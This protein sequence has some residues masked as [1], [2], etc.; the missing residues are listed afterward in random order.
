M[1]IIWE[2]LWLLCA[3]MELTGND[4]VEEEYFTLF[5]AGGR[6]KEHPGV[7]L[8]GK[9]IN[10]CNHMGKGCKLIAV[11]HLASGLKN[12]KLY[13]REHWKTYTYGEQHSVLVRKG[14]GINY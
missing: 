5:S 2:V 4:V 6:Y 1:V 8:T 9:C 10:D 7:K 11:K 3:M 13:Q 12:C 14:V